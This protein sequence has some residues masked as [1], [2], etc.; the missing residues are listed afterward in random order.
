MICLLAILGVFLMVPTIVYAE[1]SMTISGQVY[2]ADRDIYVLEPGAFIEIYIFGNDQSLSIQVDSDGSYKKT[3]NFATGD[4][5]FSVRVSGKCSY[6]TSRMGTMHI[7]EGSDLT[8]NVT[9]YEPLISGKILKP[10]GLVYIQGQDPN[11]KYSPVVYVTGNGQEDIVSLNEDGVYKAGAGFKS[12]VYTVWASFVAV[13]SKPVTVNLTEGKLTTLDLQL[14]VLPPGLTAGIGDNPVINPPSDDLAN[15]T[16]AKNFTDVQ[17][18][19]WAYEQIQALVEAGVVSGYPDGTYRPEQKVTREEFARMLV[20]ALDIPLTENAAQTFSDVK[21]GQWS[22]SAI[23]AV[24]TYLPGYTNP[25]GTRSFRGKKPVLRE[26]VATALVRAKGLYL[27]QA[28]DVAKLQEMFKDFNSISPSLA[29]YVALAV[30]NNL[31]SGYPDG[32]FRG[33]NPLNRAEVAALFFKANQLGD[34]NKDI[35]E[36]T[37]PQ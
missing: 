28:G 17:E 33:Q 9:L 10:D 3:A 6:I 4:Y 26:D 19:Y 8:Q 29:K 7:E 25:D 37:T 21:P 23:E 20:L 36:D 31:I 11:D 30:E 14:D 35:I 13:Q 5:C 22:F 18:S 15:S 27:T 2:T 1:E 24:K 32:T 34:G 12:G 16:K